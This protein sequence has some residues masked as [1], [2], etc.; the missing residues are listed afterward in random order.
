MSLTVNRNLQP[1]TRF[2]FVSAGKA[3]N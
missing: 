3:V 1:S 2:R